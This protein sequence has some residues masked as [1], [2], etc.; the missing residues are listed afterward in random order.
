MAVRQLERRCDRFDFS[1]DCDHGWEQDCYGQLHSGDADADT[2]SDCSARVPGGRG[3]IRTAGSD[4]HANT[5]SGNAHTYAYYGVSNANASG[6]RDT[7]T[8]SGNNG[9]WGCDIA[10]AGGNSDTDTNS[11]S[12]TRTR[13]TRSTLVHNRRDNRWGNSCRAVIVLP[14]AQKRPNAG[15]SDKI[16][17]YEI[18]IY[19]RTPANY[20]LCIAAVRG[21]RIRWIAGAITAVGLLVDSVAVRRTGVLVG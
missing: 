3:R 13:S 14:A 8:N 5:G 20:G 16:L 1:H 21:S 17:D 11:N 10:D 9:D 6:N 7:D 15:S 18:E 4:T 2:N 12:N 19:S